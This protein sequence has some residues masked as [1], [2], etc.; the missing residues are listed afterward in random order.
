MRYI[1]LILSLFMLTNLG[2]QDVD[3]KEKR[4][5]EKERREQEIIKNYNATLAFVEGKKFVL[6]ANF[7]QDK[8]GNRISVIKDI[9][10]IYVDSEDAVLQIGNASGA[11]Y[12]GVGGVTIEGKISKWNLSKDDKRHTILLE[13]G[14]MGSTGIYDVL[15]NINSDRKTSAALTSLSYGRL[16][17]IGD[18]VSLENSRVYKALTTY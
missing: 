7:L 1:F 10:F 16:D 15:L 14:I 4:K 9:N 2:A 8:Y 13:L 3:K 11:G 5:Q 6:E 12:N 18:L 17:Y